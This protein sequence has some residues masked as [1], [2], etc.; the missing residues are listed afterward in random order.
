M[1]YSIENFEHNGLTVRIV[2]DE[3][4]ESPREWDNLGKMVCW[5]RRY[6]L[7]DKHHFNAPEDFYAFLKETPCIVLPLY[8]YDHSGLTMN[9]TG[10]SCPWDSGQVGYIYMSLKDV[11][12]EYSVKRVSK[13]L[14]EKIEGYLRNEVATFD[15]YLT[16]DVYGY[17]IENEDGEELDSCYGFYGLEYVKKE[18]VNM[19]EYFTTKQNAA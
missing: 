19:V 4:C 10:F 7:G 3:D 17:I 11:R 13:K 14:R 18:A 5:R 12:K 8:L 9:T 2:N 16:G 1:S 15:S 6:N